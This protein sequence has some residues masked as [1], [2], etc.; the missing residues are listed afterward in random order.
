M[1]GWMDRFRER[2]GERERERL[3]I[4]L[5]FVP[6]AAAGE[7]RGRDAAAFAADVFVAVGGHEWGRCSAVALGLELG[8]GL[9][10]GVG[11]RVWVKVRVGHRLRVG[12]EAVLHPRA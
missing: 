1:D 6:G 12:H 4:S 11:L 3:P 8:L 2:E 7:T 5:S 10:V 9:A